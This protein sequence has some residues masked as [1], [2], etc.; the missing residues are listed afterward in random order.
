[1]SFR[2]SDFTFYATIGQLFLTTFF[3]SSRFSPDQ[4][5][6]GLGNGML[7]FFSYSAGMSPILF[8]VNAFTLLV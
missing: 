3:F 2:S 5:I 8:S 6:A 1:M 7:A 4:V